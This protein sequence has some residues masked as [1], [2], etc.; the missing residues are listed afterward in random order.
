MPR[1]ALLRTEQKTVEL[2]LSK[3]V[4]V[5]HVIIGMNFDRSQPDDLIAVQDAD[6]F[7]VGG[8]LQ[9]DDKLVR[10]CV[11]DSVIMRRY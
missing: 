11:G 1:D 8:T 9:S 3:A 2:S 5:K 7:A 6:V 10:A 4:F